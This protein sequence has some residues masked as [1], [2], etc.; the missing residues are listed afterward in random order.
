MKEE[1]KQHLNL[2]IRT[3]KKVGHT[4]PGRNT[5]DTYITVGTRGVTT[6]H[7]TQARR[8]FG[9]PM[10]ETEVFRKQKYCVEESACDIVGAFRR[11]P[12]RFGPP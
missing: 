2:Q 12:Q 7:G 4:Y 10:F 11:P 9:T 6:L 3:L 1:K 8:R 5:W